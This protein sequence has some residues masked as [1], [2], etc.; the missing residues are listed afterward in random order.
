M[1]DSVV[2]N[3]FKHAEETQPRECCGLVIAVG[4]DIEYVPC[5]NLSPH[6][7]TFVLDPQDY[8]AAEDRG[9]IVAIAHSHVYEN[10]EPSMADIESC[11]SSALPWLIV[12]Y[13]T[14]KHTVTLPG[15]REVPLLDRPF[16][17][18]VFDCY[19]LVRAYFYKERGVALPAYIYS[20]PV[21]EVG[22]SL[23][24]DLFQSFGFQSIKQD[25]VL[26]GDCFL[27]NVRSTAANHC[28][29]YLGD[30]MIL[31]HVTNCLSRREPYSGYWRRATV[32]TLRY[33]K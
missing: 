28:A 14:G 23:F 15:E 27:M 32:D 19:S 24:S 6:K 31:H 17:K 10:P 2:A 21:Y 9:R 8:A 29:V 22:K 26:P 18:G 7:D 20:D 33:I 1:F 30:N 13:P 16:V 4:K 11:N 5:R 3:V 25:D 12:N